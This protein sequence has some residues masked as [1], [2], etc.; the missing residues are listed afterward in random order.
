MLVFRLPVALAQHFIAAPPDQLGYESPDVDFGG[1]L[2]TH[3]LPQE[4]VDGPEYVRDL[5][6]I[7]LQGK[8]WYEW[9]PGQSGLFFFMLEYVRFLAELPEY[10]LK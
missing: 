6:K 9:Q 8:P 7:F 2:V 3:P 5:T 1:D 4:I 10:Q